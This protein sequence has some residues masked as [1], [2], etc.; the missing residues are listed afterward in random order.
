MCGFPCLC[1]SYSRSLFDIL[2]FIPAFLSSFVGGFF[3]LTLWK[4]VCFFRAL[5]QTKAVDGVILSC[6]IDDKRRLG[7]VPADLI[8]ARKHGLRKMDY[9]RVFADTVCGVVLTR[10]I[11]GQMTV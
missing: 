4:F 6:I 8:L 10:Q 1:L 3:H 9:K 5:R 11:L 2:S 7:L